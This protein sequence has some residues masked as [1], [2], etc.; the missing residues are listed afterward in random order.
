MILDDTISI[1]KGPPRGLN[2]WTKIQV[3]FGG[4][5]IQFGSMFFWFGMI[6]TLVFVGQS[7]LIHIFHFD[8]SWRETDGIVTDIKESNIIVNDRPLHTFDF[9]YTVDGQNFI[10]SS[11][12]R[13]DGSLQE[14]SIARVEYRSKNPNRSRIVGMTTEIFP[15]WVMFVLIFPLIGLGFLVFG[16]RANLKSLRL[17]VHGTFTRGKQIGKESTSTIVNNQRVY[18]YT[19]IFEANHQKYEA[20]CRTHLAGRVEDEAL[21]KVLYLKNNPKENVVYDGIE[22]APKVD[23][24]GRIIQAGP[25]ALRFLLISII[26]ILVNSLIAFFLFL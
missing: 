25:F 26:G 22:G 13:L 12:G 15:V 8:G 17:L 7:E 18:E 3:L 20:V 16:F 6:F 19:F 21:E 23:S 14:G 24:A 9:S 11:N 2:I 4:F 1:R 5:S 10:G